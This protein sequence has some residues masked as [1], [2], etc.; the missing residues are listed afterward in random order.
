LLLLLFLKGGGM[1]MTV[2]SWWAALLI[3]FPVLSYFL[4]YFSIKKISGNKK[5]AALSSFDLGSFLLLISIHF[6][7]MVV[8]EESILGY[9]ALLSALVFVFIAVLQRKLEEF[10]L[11]K[12]FRRG[13]RVN[14]LIYMIIYII[15][16]N[17]GIV[18]NI[19]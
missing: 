4:I 6:T 11:G 17:Y 9:I 2:I 10:S 1:E 19:I 8:F 18:R 15:I 16:F 7:S 13:W 12:S 14:G 5:R 3:T